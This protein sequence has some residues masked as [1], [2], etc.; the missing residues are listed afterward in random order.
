ML[1]LLK[2]Y[3]LVFVWFCSGV[4]AVEYISQEDKSRVAVYAQNHDENQA[5]PFT[6]NI[7]RRLTDHSQIDYDRTATDAEREVIYKA[8]MGTVIVHGVYSYNKTTTGHIGYDSHFNALQTINE[9]IQVLW[10]NVSKG[11]Y[12]DGL[13][14]I[15]NDLTRQALLTPHFV[16]WFYKTLESYRHELNFFG[17]TASFD[18]FKGADSDYSANR[19]FDKSDHGGGSCATHTYIKNEQGHVIAILKPKKP[20]EKSDWLVSL[21]AKATGLID[22]INPAIP[23]QIKGG[24]LTIDTKDFTHIVEPFV[25]FNSDQINADSPM[26]QLLRHVL[27]ANP[28]QKMDKNALLRLYNF[29]K[30]FEHGTNPSDERFNDLQTFNS[31]IDLEDV[32]KIIL[33]WRFF[34]IDDMHDCNVFLRVKSEGKFSFVVI[35]YNRCYMGSG[36]SSPSLVLLKQ[37][38][39]PI[40][41]GPQKIMQR[42]IS[43]SIKRVYESYSEGSRLPS[44]TDCHQELEKFVQE[45]ATVREIMSKFNIQSLERSY[46]AR[47][48]FYS[49]SVVVAPPP[50]SLSFYAKIAPIV[51]KHINCFWPLDIR[52]LGEA[53]QDMK[54]RSTYEYNGHF[55]VDFPK[56]TDS[57][58]IDFGHGEYTTYQVR[59][60]LYDWVFS[61]ADA[62][63]LERGRFFKS[64]VKLDR[65]DSA[66]LCVW[67]HP[68]LLFGEFFHPR[69]AQILPSQGH[70][71]KIFE[72]K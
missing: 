18:W 4:Y 42:I 27:D 35:D 33:F 21:S 47:R 68:A 50:K 34:G 1:M 26:G 23:V 25:G 19:K 67:R 16:K 3:F 20:T 57:T 13:S 44:F 39:Q 54:E 55:Y 43:K 36:Q 59:P 15:T 11:R 32:V 61:V 60:S 5:K 10:T 2:A 6:D 12:I 65:E 58:S 29:A 70:L 66:S 48:K 53:S 17:G 7:S 51:G 62:S 64:T 71:M 9:S 45:G 31:A 30:Y 63:Q 37:A 38:L 49:N 41:F 24:R 69:Y 28:K 56:L 8:M 40:N 52:P 22:V 72:I 46:Q 14:Q